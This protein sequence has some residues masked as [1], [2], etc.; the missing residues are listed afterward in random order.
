MKRPATTWVERAYALSLYLLPRDFRR[1]FG[2]EM[3][4]AFRD[5]VDERRRENRSRARFVLSMLRDGSG[6][7]VREHLTAGEHAPLKIFL[8][9]ALLIAGVGVFAAREG[10]GASLVDAVVAFQ[11]QR[12][13]DA[14]A[15]YD[16]AVHDY[17]ATIAD[18]LSGDPAARAQLMAAQF[19]SDELDYFG[20]RFDAA[21]PRDAG[22][23]ANRARAAR[24]AL[25]N[26]LDSGADDAVVLWNAATLCAEPVCRAND[27]LA[28]LEIIAPDNG[29]VWWLDFGAA[30]NAGDES[31]ARRAVA[32]MANSSQF[33]VYE[34]EMVRLWLR[35]YEL[36]T[37]P[38]RLASL[39]PHAGSAEGVIADGI[40]NRIE[41]LEW[42]AARGYAAFERVC[43]AESIRQDCARAA[44]LMAKSN[45][46]E[47]RRTGMRIA[48]FVART[49]EK[50]LHA[51]W[52]QSLWRRVQQAKLL[53][54]ADRIDAPYDTAQPA[55]W[56]AALRKTGT[57][58][59]AADEL[60]RTRA[61]EPTVEA[62]WSDG[63]PIDPTRWP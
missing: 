12:K 32:A 51:A 38:E 46:F 27:V 55:V 3:R 53:Y 37:P 29:A 41:K 58:V 35:A 2:D 57:L 6:C 28:R 14:L 19:Y 45:V 30:I 23:R 24:V 43:R 4:R 52:R 54:D 10:I 40:S 62:Q 17:T 5:R 59:G 22:Q 63:W 60:A 16:R 44:D 8:F 1:E 48:S 21:Q 39:W 25:K 20:Y 9:A 47:A 33:S 56:M 18:R 50:E 42:W 61:I 15:D 11:Q 13:A 36:V 26:A 49:N 7:L 31:R 34:N